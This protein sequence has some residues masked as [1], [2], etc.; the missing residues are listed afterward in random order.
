MQRS[1]SVP[2][3][4]DAGRTAMIAREVQRQRRR[5]GGE[6]GLMLRQN[7]QSSAP[8]WALPRRLLAA[9]AP[10]QRGGEVELVLLEGKRAAG[11]RSRGRPAAMA[12]DAA[13]GA[14]ASAPTRR[15]GQ[16][17]LELTSCFALRCEPPS[18]GRAASQYAAGTYGDADEALLLRSVTSARNVPARAAR[19]KRSIGFSL[20]EKSSSA[21]NSLRYVVARG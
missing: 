7:R 21:S 3:P 4:G 19:T 18:D 15:G 20:T 2:P 16:V 12:A 17:N 8:K 13:I 6:E 10:A 11:S 9:R 5:V 1:R 14:S